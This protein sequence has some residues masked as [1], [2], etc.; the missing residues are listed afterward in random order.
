[1]ALHGV[2]VRS[3]LCAPSAWHMG[4]LATF[5]KGFYMDVIFQEL[6]KDL[7]QNFFDEFISVV[8]YRCKIIEYQR[9]KNCCVHP[10][11]ENAPRKTLLI[12]SFRY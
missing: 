10:T 4:F 1:M 8:N 9:V 12:L 3:F 5:C 7:I 2:C 11:V 6:L